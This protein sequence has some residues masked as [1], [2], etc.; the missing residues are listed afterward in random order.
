MTVLGFLTLP[1]IVATSA[2]TQPM[3]QY[4]TASDNGT[5]LP[6]STNQVIPLATCT[7]VNQQNVALAPTYGLT[8]SLSADRL[9]ATFNAPYGISVTQSCMPAGSWIEALPK[10]PLSGAL[11]RAP[12]PVQCPLAGAQTMVLFTFGQSRAAN[13]VESRYSAGP[14]AFQLFG[15][16]CY[17]L[18]DPLLGTDSNDGSVWSRLADL[19][20]AAG[21]YNRVVIVPTAVSGSSVTHWAPG[22]NLNSQLIGAV[23][24]TITAG[25]PITHMAWDQ[26]PAD[27]GMTAEQYRDSFLAMLASIRPLTTAPVYVARSAN[28]LIRSGNMPQAQIDALIWRGPNVYV[29][30][31]TR[32]SWIRQGQAMV[33]NGF[34]VRTGPDIDALGPEIYYD[35]CHP[36]RI[37]GAIYA[38]KWLD[39]MTAQ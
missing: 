29:A 31:E 28:C 10:R 35:G 3:L 38:K 14:N 8:A 16:S 21:T 9:S 6:A 7:A 32:K 24:S 22:G 30:D 4:I 18:S 25:L 17:P 2:E 26:G 12:E 27:L 39:A 33:V 5:A 37:G 13:N 15:G 1:S 20:L 34:G 36:S 19:I 23:Q 11:P